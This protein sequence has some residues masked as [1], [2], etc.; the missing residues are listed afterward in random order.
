MA[1]AYVEI[2]HNWSDIAT[3]LMAWMPPPDGI[4]MCQCDEC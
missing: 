2:G 1:E 3:L 4:V